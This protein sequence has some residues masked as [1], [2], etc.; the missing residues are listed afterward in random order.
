[1]HHLRVTLKETTECYRGQNENVKM[2]IRAIGLFL[3]VTGI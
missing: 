3:L 1:M 2:L